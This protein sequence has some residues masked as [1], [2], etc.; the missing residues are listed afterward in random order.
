MR[1][2]IIMNDGDTKPAGMKFEICPKCK[3][4]LFIPQR[5]KLW[6]FITNNYFNLSLLFIPRKYRP[7]GDGRFSEYRKHN[8]VDNMYRCPVCND[9]VWQCTSNFKED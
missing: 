2:P 6:Q 7:R 4:K 3:T 9:R 5:S 1:K 8:R